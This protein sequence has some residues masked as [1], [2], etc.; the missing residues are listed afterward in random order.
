MTRQGQG[1]WSATQTGNTR[2]IPAP[3][4]CNFPASAAPLKLLWIPTLCCF[5]PH[6]RSSSMWWVTRQFFLEELM[7][8]KGQPWF[9]GFTEYQ[10]PRTARSAWRMARSTGVA[11]QQLEFQSTS[12]LCNTS[13][14]PPARLSSRT[15][16][17]FSAPYLW[18]PSVHVG[19]VARKTKPVTKRQKKFKLA[20]G[21]VNSEGKIP[22][23][24]IVTPSTAF[25]RNTLADKCGESEERDS[26]KP[27]DVVIFSGFL[28][29]KSWE[30]T[31]WP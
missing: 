8:W 10:H 6:E 20:G 9:K 5:Q 28:Q 4:S 14:T 30:M 15:W 18:L 3:K 27:V 29:R 1:E 21:D 19:K 24:S 2:L 31:A 7:R 25:F 26:V 13:A 16:G 17:C 11:F 23:P 12:G 22:F